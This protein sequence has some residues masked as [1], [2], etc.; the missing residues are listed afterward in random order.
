M[1]NCAGCLVAHRAKR[2]PY[3]CV[4]GLVYIGPNVEAI[5]SRS[6]AAPRRTF[7]TVLRELVGCGCSLPCRKWDR[8]GL[9]WCR[10]NAEQIAQRLTEQPRPAVPIDRARELV[11]LA[12]EIAERA[13]ER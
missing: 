4:C 8:L 9:D 6:F 5:T 11:R 13:T 2:L 10:D 1:G 3:R 12:I 7:G